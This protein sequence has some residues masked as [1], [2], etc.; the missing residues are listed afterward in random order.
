MAIHKEPRRA[1]EHVVSEANG[2]R[3]R[4]QATLAAG[5]CAA[6][7][8]L[9]LNATGDYVPLDPV[10]TDGTQTAKA[11]LYAPVDASTAPQPCVVHVRACE[12]HEEALTWPDGAS[13]AQI[14]TATNDL[15]GLGV[16]VR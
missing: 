4:E 8:V 12:V 15:V 5:N 14:D 13:Q 2:A 10:A 6:G 16:I 3:S 11:V 1:G 9:A 7:T